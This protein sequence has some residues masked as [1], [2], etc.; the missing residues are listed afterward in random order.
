MLHLLE[1]VLGWVAVLVGS[2]VMYFTGRYWIDGILTIGIA[3]YILY[4]AT[5]NLKNTADIFLQSAPED[6]SVNH[7]VENLKNLTLVRDVHDVHVWSLDG[8]Y[9]IASLHLVVEKNLTKEQRKDIMD[10]MK[11]NHIQHPTIQIEYP[12]GLCH[13][14]D[15]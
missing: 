15:C 3:C 12:D 2:I 10:I 7:L 11:D 9:T 14:K 13:E 1:D 4:N 8:S 5:R 6:V